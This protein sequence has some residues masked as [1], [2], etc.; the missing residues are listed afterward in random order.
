MSYSASDYSPRLSDMAIVL[1]LSADTKDCPGC[2]A[3][4]PG[5]YTFHGCD[6]PH[7]EYIG[8]YKCLA[9]C[10]V[11]TH[12]E[13]QFCG[14]HLNPIPMD[15]LKRPLLACLQCESED[16]GECEIE[17]ARRLA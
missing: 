7:C 14:L 12:G 15:G 13:K 9:G 17:R 4:H 1:G 16:L 8:C 11:A 5:S 6:Q 3:E 10:Q 2:N